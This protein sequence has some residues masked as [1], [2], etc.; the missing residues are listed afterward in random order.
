MMLSQVGY[1]HQYQLAAKITMAYT[2]T[3]LRTVFWC[4]AG[5][6]TFARKL[7]DHLREIIAVF[8]AA[9]RILLKG[10]QNSCFRIPGGGGGQ[11]LHAVHYI[12]KFQRG[13]NIQQGGGKCP[14]AHPPPLKKTLDCC[15]LQITKQTEGQPQRQ[16]T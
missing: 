15:I 7:Q 9:F 1:I 4:A 12:V 10:G 14:P 5:G 11:A 8:R 2:S 13:A 6:S 3:T 16:K